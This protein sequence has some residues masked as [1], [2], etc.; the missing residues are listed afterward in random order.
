MQ[1]HATIPAVFHPYYTQYDTYL[2]RYK[3]SNSNKANE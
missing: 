2:M 1:E 3:D